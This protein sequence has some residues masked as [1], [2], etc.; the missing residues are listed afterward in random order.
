[1]MEFTYKGYAELL[2]LLAGT[3]YVFAD[4]HNYVEQG[5][6][7]ILR[8]D[9]DRSPRFTLPLAEIE[10]EHQATSTWFVR[11]SSDMYNALS[12]TSRN[13]LRSLQ[14]MGHEIGLHFDEAAYTAED[15]TMEELI[16]RE[17][18]ILANALG[19]PVSTVSMH[20]PAQHILNGNIDIPGMVNAYSRVFFQD[21]KYLS[22]SRRHWREPVEE[23]AAS[24][25]YPRLNILTH[26]FWYRDKEETMEDIVRRFI[27]SANWERYQSM[28]VDWTDLSSVLRE[29]D[30]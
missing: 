4:Y 9:I 8:H 19:S 22:D 13:D 27:T 15:G 6:C 16:R 7:V 23:I 10:A 12:Q 20:R 14:S 21:F 1:M 29:G 24:G 5:R 11:L 18:D 2:K 28:A 17:A 26:A 25:T 3:G 30:V